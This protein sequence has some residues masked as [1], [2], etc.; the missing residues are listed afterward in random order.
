[1]RQINNGFCSYYYLDESGNVKNIKT[2][3]YLKMNN[4]NYILRTESGENKKVSLKELYM[5]I[6]NKNFCIDNIE[7][8][9]NEEWK[10][11][12]DFPTYYISSKGRLKSCCGYNSIIVKEIIT[13]KGYSKVML[14]YKGMKVKKFVHR[15]VIEAFKGKPLSEDFQAHHLNRQ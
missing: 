12:Q 2:N 14:Y 15:L 6:Y 9:E 5:L 3:K 4:Y 1:M 8:L 13:E 10:Q 7:N 11:V